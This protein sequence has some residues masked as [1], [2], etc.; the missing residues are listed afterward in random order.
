[1]KAVILAAGK[2]SRLS[3]TTDSVPKP[4]IKLG[5]F[6]IIHHII[7]Q[8]PNEIDEVF[9]VVDYLGHLIEGYFQDK[10][11]KQKIICVK[12]GDIRGTYGALKSVEPYLTERFLVINGDDL[13]SKEELSSLLIYNRSFGIQCSVMPGYHAI[14]VTDSG[15]IDSFRPQTEEEK[16]NGAFVATGAYVLDTDFFSHLPISISGGEYGIPQ[17]IV[18]A[19]NYPVRAVT[20]MLWK[21]INT[22][23]DL[24]RARDFMV[25]KLT[26]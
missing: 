4:L 8:L 14:E 17:T 21:P 10:N 15:D 22:H 18:E 9:V 1:M 5:E 20:S 19:K 26:K 24:E 7:D 2:G 16:K 6:P 13:H 3:P 11:Y 12:Q 25:D 23:S